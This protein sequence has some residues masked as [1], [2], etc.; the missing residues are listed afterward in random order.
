MSSI[1]LF[2]SWRGKRQQH[3]GINHSF[4]H[5][6]E[7]GFCVYKSCIFLSSFLIDYW[8]RC[9]SLQLQ[10][11]SCCCKCSQ[12]NFI[13]HRGT[14]CLSTLSYNTRTRHITLEIT[15]CNTYRYHWYVNHEL[16][17]MIIFIINYFALWKKLCTLQLQ[18]H[19][20][21]FKWLLLPQQQSKRFSV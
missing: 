17:L 2:T 12:Y 4:I 9:A 11:L 5:V 20:D 19:G 18:T 13:F 1:L 10:V 8:R 16:Q 15:T 3:G 14:L 6:G 21:V 7:S